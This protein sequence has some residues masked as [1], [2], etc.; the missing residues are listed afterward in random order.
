MWHGLVKIL[1]ITKK[2]IDG[3]VLWRKENILNVLHE[4]GEELLLKALFIGGKSS[5]DYI[6]TNYYFGLDNRLSVSASDTVDEL[7]EEPTAG[8][9]YVRQAVPSLNTFTVTQI[10]GVYV[11]QSPIISFQGVGGSWGPVRNLFLIDKSNNTD[12]TLISSN[13]LS[14]A[15]TVSNSETISLRLL[16]SL[17]DCP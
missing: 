12:A 4:S 11:A 3:N 13:N 10:G 17:R 2:D 8:T 1:E 6:P 7:V 16:L 15:I 9:G 14:S 5:N